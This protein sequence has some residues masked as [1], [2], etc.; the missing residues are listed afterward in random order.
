MTEGKYLDVELWGEAR[1]GDLARVKAQMSA[2]GLTMPDM[3]VLMLY[4]GLDNF[5]KIGLT[6]FWIVNDEEAGYCGKL[7]FL[8]DGQTCPEHH[9]DMKHETFFVVKGKVMMRVDGK[10]RE[11]VEGDLLAMHRGMTHAFTGVGSALLIEVSQP[12]VRDD[13]FFTDKQ[14]GKDGVI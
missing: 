3:K 10:E 4:F 12:C 1:D 5:D 8:F 14:I 13:N 2:W 9:H 6:E 11:M 7:L